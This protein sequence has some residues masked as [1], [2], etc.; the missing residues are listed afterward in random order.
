MKRAGHPSSCTDN[1]CSLT[2][3]DHLLGIGVLAAALPS[4][5]RA[6]IGTNN[7]EST[8][9]RDLDAYKRM[10]NDGLQPPQID[11]ARVLEAKATHAEQV[12]TGKPEVSER[13]FRVFRE[14]FGHSAA[15]V[16][17]R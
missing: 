9:S 8:L 15:E 2:Y 1:D 14:E 3:R 12:N 11:G 16:G 13:A 4:R 10:R 17:P 6:I 5:R 7:R